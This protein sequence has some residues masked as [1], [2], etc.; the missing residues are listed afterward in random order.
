MRI[1]LDAMG[2]D[3]AP[4]N[5]VEGAILANREWGIQTILVG[6]KNAIEPYLQNN[7][8]RKEAIKIH[9]TDE[10]IGMDENVQAL[11]LKK[12]ASIVETAKLVKTDQAQA[13]VAFGNTSVSMAAACINLGRI[14]AINRPAIATIFP[15]KHGPAIFLD[16][17]AVADAD[18]INLWQFALMGKAYAQK[19]AKIPNPRIALLSVGSEEN[20]GNTIV[21][22]AFQKF[23]NLEGF[24]GNIE[25]NNLFANHADVIVADGFIGNIVLKAI[26]G[27]VDLIMGKIK[28]ESISHPKASLCQLALATLFNNLRTKLDYSEYGG[29]PLLGLEQICII[30]HGR[31]NARAVANALRTAKTAHESNLVAAIKE[32][33]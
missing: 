22:E 14:S 21:K 24:V 16:A 8:Y 12:K 7:G 10:I 4:Q 33:F 28:E 18:V 1:A 26:E 32:S 11:R 13:M 2:G 15:G 20:K 23:K 17:G 27:T 31:S 19:V 6:Q 5:L 30:G 25:G 29:A 3:F 9:H